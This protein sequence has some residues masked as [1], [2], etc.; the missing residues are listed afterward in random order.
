VSRRDLE[1]K[2]ISPKKA[3][4][5][6]NFL[7]HVL[8]NQVQRPQILRKPLGF[9]PLSMPQTLRIGWFSAFI[10]AQNL[11]NRLVFRFYLYPK[12]KNAWLSAIMHTTPPALSPVSAPYFSAYPSHKLS[13]FAP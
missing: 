9:P 12:F 7:R 8:N 13:L 1:T 2:H 5:A 6:S 10:Y 11:K 4:H 3:C